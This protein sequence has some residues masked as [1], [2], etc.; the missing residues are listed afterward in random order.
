MS[1]IRPEARETLMTW[2]EV[3]FGVILMAIGVNWTIS[4][5][6]LA[7]ILGAVIAVIGAAVAFVGWRRVQLPKGGGGPGI[8][9]VDERRIAYLSGHGG[10]ALSVEALVRVEVETSPSGRLIWRFRDDEGQVLNIPS[11]A[12]GAEELLDALVSLPGLNYDQAAQAVRAERTDRFL[13]WQKDRR[14]LH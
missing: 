13:I 11:D 8:V 4:G 12:T 5:T 6:G 9:E 2:R 1:W 7:P 10:G 3:G 14:A